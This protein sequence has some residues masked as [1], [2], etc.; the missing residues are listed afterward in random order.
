MKIDDIKVDEE[1]A[2][3]DN[4]YGSRGR[5]LRVKALAIETQE[6]HVY[7]RNGG[8]ATKRKVRYVKIARLDLVTGE[9]PNE[10]TRQLVPP[11]DIVG[12][13]AE[14][15]AYEQARAE[16]Q[17]AVAAAVKDLQAAFDGARIKARVTGYSDALT[18]HIDRGETAKLVALLTDG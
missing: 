2:F 12:P 8:P 3:G 14:Y 6:E 9:E 15:G 4:S 13:W 18:I 16:K 1:Y 11:R 10:A 17:A 7:P 5:K